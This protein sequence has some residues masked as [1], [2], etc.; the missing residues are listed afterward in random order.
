MSTWVVDSR[1]VG[2]VHMKVSHVSSCTF[3]R[4]FYWN[5]CQQTGS[6]RGENYCRGCSIRSNP[7]WQKQHRDVFVSNCH[8]SRKSRKGAISTQ[9]G[10]SHSLR[11]KSPSCFR[12]SRRRKAN[13]DRSKSVALCHVRGNGHHTT[14]PRRMRPYWAYVSVETTKLRVSVRVQVGERVPL[15]LFMCFCGHFWEL[16]SNTDSLEGSADEREICK[17]TFV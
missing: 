11:S 15:V 16:Q 17:G 6:N 8:L 2:E 7:T 14:W 13:I 12:N 5:S 9:K 10:R 1:T 4:H 3:P